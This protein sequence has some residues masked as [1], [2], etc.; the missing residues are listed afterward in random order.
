MSRTRAGKSRL[1]EN[2]ETVKGLRLPEG[3]GF[4]CLRLP[5][6]LGAVWPKAP[7]ARKPAGPT[8]CEPRSDVMR[9]AHGSSGA[10][11]QSGASPAAPAQKQ[12]QG[13]DSRVLQPAV[14]FILEREWLPFRFSAFMGV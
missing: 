7:T 1:R 2:A 3:F 12:E 9:A 14:H 6:A 4:P 10:P 8:P 5:G 11:G 13:P